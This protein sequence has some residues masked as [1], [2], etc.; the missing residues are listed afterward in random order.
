[1][2]DLKEKIQK[3]FALGEFLH[4]G[5]A[6]AHGIDMSNPP[7]DV[8]KNIKEVMAPK[9]QQARDILGDYILHVTSCWRPEALNDLLPG[10]PPKK[11]AHPEALAIDIVSD[12]HDLRTMFN[13]LVKDPTFMSDVDQIIIERGCVHVGMPCAS[14]NYGTPR[15]EL[16]SERWDGNEGIRTYPLLGHWTPNGIVG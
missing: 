12:H 4:S 14:T 2:L 1:M 13:M 10:R 9:A 15:H 6:E 7:E 16:R 3:N 8:L 5:M 11:G